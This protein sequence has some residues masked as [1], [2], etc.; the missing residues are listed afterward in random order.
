MRLT[1]SQYYLF[2]EQIQWVNAVLKLVGVNLK[3]SCGGE[4]KL[5]L[6]DFYQNNL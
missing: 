3:L 6:T 5:Y 1:R 2:I 4:T